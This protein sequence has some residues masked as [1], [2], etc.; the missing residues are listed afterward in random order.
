MVSGKLGINHGREANLD[1]VH[2]TAIGLGEE[3]PDSRSV[4]MYSSKLN[5]AGQRERCIWLDKSILRHGIL[6]LDV[7]ATSTQKSGR[8]SLIELYSDNRLLNRTK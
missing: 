2:T 1:K 4:S 7:L 5:V 8:R 3:S 6:P